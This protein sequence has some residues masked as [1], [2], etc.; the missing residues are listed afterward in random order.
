MARKYKTYTEPKEC[1]TCKIVKNSEE[2]SNS[3][4]YC[5]K[6]EPEIV[7]YRK[8]SRCKT[9][10][11]NISKTKLKNLTPDQLLERKKERSLWRKNSSSDKV[12]RRNSFLKLMYGITLTEYSE[13]FEEQNGMCKIC[14]KEESTLSPQRRYTRT[15]SVDH[16]HSTGKVRG[17]LCKCCNTGLGAFSDNIEVLTSAIKY[18]NQFSEN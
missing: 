17:L 18:L 5:I 16:C 12:T 3:G 7:I 9:C 14:K 1:V 11:S 2:F 4:K 13:M 8:R 10:E 6:K 15:L